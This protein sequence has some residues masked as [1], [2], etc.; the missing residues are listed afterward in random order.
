MKLNLARSMSS[1]NE[2]KHSKLMKLCCKCCNWEDDGRGGG[3]VVDHR[4]PD[5]RVPLADLH[6]LLHHLLLAADG[7]PGVRVVRESSIGL[8]RCHNLRSKESVSALQ[9]LIADSIALLQA[10]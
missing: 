5:P 1:I 2:Q 3:D 6:H 7:E 4:E 10:L 8:K 9:R